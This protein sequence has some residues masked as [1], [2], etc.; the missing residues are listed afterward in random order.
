[1]QRS[2]E[3][4]LF[5]DISIDMLV[6][7]CIINVNGD[8]GDGCDQNNGDS[9]KELRTIETCVQEVCVVSLR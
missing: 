9:E 2:E 4:Y 7:V 3:E 1:M 6:G 5:I 8:T